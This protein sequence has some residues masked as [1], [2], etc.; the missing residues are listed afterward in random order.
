MGSAEGRCKKRPLSAIRRANYAARTRRQKNTAGP[1]QTFFKSPNLNNN[2]L[3]RES[4]RE[5]RSPNFVSKFHEL[6][7]PVR[8][9]RDYCTFVLFRGEVLLPLIPANKIEWLGRLGYSSVYCHPPASHH[10]LI[11]PRMPTPVTVKECK[12]N[13]L[14]S[15]DSNGPLIITQTYSHN[16]VAQVFCC[17]ARLVASGARRSRTPALSLPKTILII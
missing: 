7:C 1:S 17:D 3:T 12:I 5:M 16:E 10:S 9:C 2:A 6:R 8:F 15:T 13:C 14:H 4:I 11:A